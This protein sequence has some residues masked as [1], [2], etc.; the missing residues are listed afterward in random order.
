MHAAAC[1]PRFQDP[2]QCRRLC[3]AKLGNLAHLA[4]RLPGQ[5]IRHL[6]AQLDRLHLPAPVASVVHLNGLRDA[7]ALLGLQDTPCLGLK[8]EL[9]ALNIP[10]SR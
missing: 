1:Y 7:A 3:D 5:S 4:H 8:R 9:V 2:L 6:E 10:I